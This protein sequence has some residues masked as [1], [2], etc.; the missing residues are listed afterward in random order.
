MNHSTRNVTV[1][2]LALV[3]TAR[4]VPYG[5]V[6]LGPGGAYGINDAGQVVGFSGTTGRAFL[7]DNGALSSMETLG[8][9]WS[10]AYA[11]NEASHVVGT[12]PTGAGMP[13]AFLREDGV[14]ADLGTLG[15]PV[16]EAHGI[17]D[18]GQIVGYSDFAIAFVWDKANGMRAI[19]TFSDDNPL[20]VAN[21]INNSGQVVGYSATESGPAHAFLWDESNGLQDLGTLPGYDS[22]GAYGINDSGEVVGVVGSHPFVWDADSGMQDLGTLWPEN[23][24]TA[25]AINNAGQAVG[26]SVS[27]GGGPSQHAFLWANGVLTDLD[28]LLAPG[29]LWNLT[30][31]WDINDAG[32][33]VGR[34]TIN[35]EMH[36]F[37]LTPIPEPRTVVLLALTACALLRHR[38][39]RAGV[40]GTYYKGST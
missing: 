31:A 28:D 13:H 30:D 40:R 22:S 33:I 29:S 2:L 12:S 32:Q 5:I 17:N 34:G 19:G 24:T 37:L 7:W 4:G 18:A 10:A 21:A 8:G 3:S 11:I 25:V 38:R 39:W 16:S 6:D 1:V 15:G 36:A 23:L 20:S 14:M 27:P 9:E 26:S 35:G